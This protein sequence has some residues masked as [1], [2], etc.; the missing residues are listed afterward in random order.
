MHKAVLTIDV[1][2]WFCV[3]NFQNSIGFEQW[4]GCEQRVSNGMDFVLRELKSRNIQATF[5][6][7]GWIAEKHPEVVRAIA[8]DGHEIESHGYSHRAIEEL[9]PAE[10]CVEIQRSRILIE[11]ITGKKVRGFRAPSFSITHDTLWAL[12]VLKENGIQYDSSI[13]PVRHPNYGIPEF[14]EEVQ[15]V[16]GLI[17]VPM[18]TFRGIPISGGGFFRLYP[19]A[20]S[21]NLLKRVL[22][23]RHAILYFHPWEFD[24]EQPRVSSISAFASFRHYT[25]LRKNREKFTRLLNDFEFVPMGGLLSQKGFVLS[26]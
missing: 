5:F 17:E 19:Y 3:R 16:G 12:D 9:T 4:E 2:D 13:Y 20:V 23:K 15:D 24:E 22:K 8:E 10:L 6:V 25:G 21:Q 7:L 26:G 11:A 14:G 1:E 18:T